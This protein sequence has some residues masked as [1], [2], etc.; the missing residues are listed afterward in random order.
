MQRR[1]IVMR[2]AKSSWDS[3]A[4]SDH[5]RPLNAR[6]RRDAPNVAEK[7]VQLGWIPQLVLSS[8]SQRTSETIGRMADAF[9]TEPEVRFLRSFYHA[10]VD[11]VRDALAGVSDD[12]ACVMLL[13]HNPGWQ[14]VVAWLGGESIA[15]TTANAALLEAA[16]NDW[17]QCVASGGRWTLRTV[18]RPKEL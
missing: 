12:V 5:Q 11:A 1:L 4:P 18:I 2:H 15:M 9:G 17:Q 7:L 13:G 6:G 10:G 14:Q 8:D 3:D 16:G